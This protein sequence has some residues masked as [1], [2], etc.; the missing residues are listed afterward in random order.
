MKYRDIEIPEELLPDNSWIESAKSL[1]D[2]YVET[3]EALE[4]ATQNASASDI[5]GLMAKVNTEKIALMIGADLRDYDKEILMGV[6]E[7]YI[8]GKVFKG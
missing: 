7:R 8:A 3:Y 6:I 4:G 5:I 2:N 1:D